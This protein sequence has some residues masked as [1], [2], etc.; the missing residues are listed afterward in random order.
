M[1][2][3]DVFFLEILLFDRTF[4]TVVLLYYSTIV[5]VLCCLFISCQHFL[6]S[7]GNT[8]HCS[9]HDVIKTRLRLICLTH[10]FLFCLFL[11]LCGCFN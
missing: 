3:G 5:R 2:F 11:L 6:C 10:D 4:S 1:C 9:V 8:L 7:A